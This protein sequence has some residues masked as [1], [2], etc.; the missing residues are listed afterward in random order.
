[1]THDSCVLVA[2]QTV[3]RRHLPLGCAGGTRE[4]QDGAV[5]GNVVGVRQTIQVLDS[6]V[7]KAPIGAEL[8]TG[9]VW[10][11]DPRSARSSPRSVQ[12]PACV[13]GQKWPLRRPHRPLALRKKYDPPKIPRKIHVRLAAFMRRSE[14]MW[15]RSLLKYPLS[16][17]LAQKERRARDV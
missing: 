13:G 8:A 3:A 14:E 4:P 17:A 1:M 10:V 7:T 9:G 5:H 15:D 11:H 16:I 2:Q 6:I 12:M